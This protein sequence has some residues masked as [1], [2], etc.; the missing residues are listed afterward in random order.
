MSEYDTVILG[1]GPGGYVAAIRAAQLGARVCIIEK[2]FVG[3]TCLNWGCIPTK[4]MYKCAVLYEQMCSAEDF[5]LSC[6]RP[7]A[8]LDK[9]VARNHRIVTG[10]RQGVERLFK[11]HRINLIFGRGLVRG[12]GEVEVTRT[13]QG[14]QTVRGR[15]LVIATGSEPMALDL[16]PC[17]HRRILSTRSILELERVP[18]SL[19]IVG[20]GVSGCEFAFLFSALGSTVHISKR[21]KEPIKG[22]DRDLNKTLIRALKKR[23][24]RLHLEDP[25]VAATQTPTGIEITLSSG[26]RVEA[27]TVL[28]TVGR[29]PV[30]SGIGL[31]ELGLDLAHGYI[32]V[33]RH[34]QTNVAGIYAIGDVTGK[35]ELAHFASHQ[36]LV[37]VEH[38]LGNSRAA[39]AE[40][41]VPIAI[42]TRPEIAAVGLTSEQCFEQGIAC[43]EGMFPFRALG[44]SHAIGEIDGFVKV[45]AAEKDER[46]VGM[47]MIGPDAST[48]VAECTLAVN[49]GATLGELARTIHAHP[50]VSEAV[51]EAAAEVSGL[52]IHKLDLGL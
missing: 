45:V 34:C 40:H 5:G 4:A 48:L 3:G 29:V 17:D 2:D 42:F 1:A 33:N 51:W 20:G 47:H 32:Q 50:T 44:K 28:V 11:K 7:A 37:A 13:D 27:E 16:L 26:K 18:E 43:R 19:F 38:G 39:V 52:S 6:T 12:P 22:L 15:Q 9:I 8:H 41:A 36:G 35:K 14:K 25:P 10:L 30:S 49:R 31:E 23:K 24:I 46:I 21:S